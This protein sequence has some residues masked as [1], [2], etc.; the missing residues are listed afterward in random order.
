[1][2]KDATAS[3]AYLTGEGSGS[4]YITTAQNITLTAGRWYHLRGTVEGNTAKLYLD[5]KLILTY[6]DSRVDFGSGKI[7]LS[8]WDTKASFDNVRFYPIDAFA[9]SQTYDPVTQQ[10][11]G[12]TDE[13]GVSV[14]Q[15]HDDFLRPF[16]TADTDGF[17]LSESI[18]YFSRDG[19]GD[20]FSSTDPNFVEATTFSDGNLVKNWSFEGDDSGGLPEEWGSWGQPNSMVTDSYYGSQAVKISPIEPNGNGAITQYVG[21]LQGGKTYTA[22]VWFKAATGVIGSIF[23]GD[24]D[25]P[26]PYENSVSTQLAG[27]GQWQRM[28]VTRTMS[29]DDLMMVILYNRS[30]LGPD[31]DV[32]YDG[33]I[34]EEAGTY[35]EPTVSRIFR[36]GFG[37]TIQTQTRDGSY[38]IVSQT[39]YNTTGK[40]EKQ[41]AAKRIS[42]SSHDFMASTG[43]ADYEQFDYEDDPLARLQK[44][45]HFYN[46]ANQGEI[47]FS[48]GAEQI[49]GAGSVYAYTQAQDELDKTAKS[50]RDRFG[51]TTATLRTGDIG[52]NTTYDDPLARYE[53]DILGNTTTV[54]PPNEQEGLTGTWNASSKYSTLSQVV[55]E[56]NP[57]EN[58]MFTNGPTRRYVYD[59]L[60]NL[61]FSQDAE[62]YGTS[63]YD[64][65]VYYYDAFGRITLVGVEK[66]DFGWTET[67]DPPDVSNTTYGTEASEWRIKYHYDENFVTGVANYSTSRLT[68][69]EVNDDTDAAVEHTT[70]YVY[71][72]FG[73]IIEKHIT[74]DEG[75]PLAEKTIIHI[76]DK[77]GREIQTIYP[78]GNTVSRQYDPLGRLIKVFS[79][80]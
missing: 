48:Y 75:N 64:F 71:D 17:I 24:V 32:T 44:Q 16:R 3:T 42:N 57:D 52:Y 39:T 11:I 26:N 76:Y 56:T 30:D 37:R 35:N 66:D 77:L 49:N 25:E 22:T 5:G 19:N 60:G 27:N 15:T 62:Q 12:S 45:T 58:L 61:R 69:V 29:H 18:F 2:K 34:V 55:E 7:G 28:T 1:M 51:N 65:T 63:Q 9:S 20:D 54:E 21:V 46:S 68:K 78:S 10:L 33:V 47:E 41:Y 43:L 73:N 67:S 59:D 31:G 38:D 4:S 74:I 79:I 13:N 80:Q 8:T 14:F 50:Y 70:K 53:F 36:D 72:Q 40:V 6:V 23:F